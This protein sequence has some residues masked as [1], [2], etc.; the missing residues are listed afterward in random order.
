[1]QLID[2][3]IRLGWLFEHIVQTHLS[4]L[5]EM[6]EAAGEEEQQLASEMANAF[7]DENLPEDVFGSPKAG[8]GMWASV[9][10]I[11]NPI[12][13]RTVFKLSLEQNEAAFRL[14]LFLR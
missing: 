4:S 11:V 1:M 14:K 10:R 12:L 6:I 2:C 9:I 5:Q 13:Q 7:L 8:S 3:G